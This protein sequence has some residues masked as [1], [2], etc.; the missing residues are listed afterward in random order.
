LPDEHI[1]RILG[2]VKK[3]KFNRLLYRESNPM[4]DI[5]L[6]VIILHIISPLSKLD[7]ARGL[8]SLQSA[9]SSI[10]AL[11]NLVH[12]FATLMEN[13]GILT[14]NEVS[15]SG[16]TDRVIHVTSLATEVQLTA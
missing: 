14:W 6:G 12:S 11:W 10:G 3:W 7:T 1:A 2:L 13:L 5:S 8:L 9:T 16:N 4:R 15:L